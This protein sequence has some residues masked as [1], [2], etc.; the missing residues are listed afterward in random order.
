MRENVGS[1]WLENSGAFKGACDLFFL[2][3]RAK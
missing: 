1:Q 2:D 3:E